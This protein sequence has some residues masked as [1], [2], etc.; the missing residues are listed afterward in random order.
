MISNK[1]Y[2]P[3]RKFLPFFRILLSLAA[4]WIGTL[5][6]Y[7]IY[8]ARN[9]SLVEGPYPPH[10]GS[11]FQIIIL[12]FLGIGLVCASIKP[13]WGLYALV[14]FIPLFGNHPSGPYLFLLDILLL[15]IIAN[16]IIRLLKEKDLR[17][18]R[19]HLD[20]PIIL[21]LLISLVSAIPY[22]I[23]LYQNTFQWSDIFQFFR[24]VA[25]V[26][27]H[28]PLYTMQ[29]ILNLL[30][31]VLLYL[32]AI[33]NLD[34]LKQINWLIFWLLV[35]FILTNLYGLLDYLEI[36]SLPLE[37]SE[38]TF[39]RSRNYFRYG[40]SHCV[41]ATFWNPRWYAEYLILV[42]PFLFAL[43]SIQKGYRKWLLLLTA[44]L[45]TIN[46]VLSYARGGWV[47][48]PVVIVC[49]LLLFI[50]TSQTPSKRKKP[51]RKIWWSLG[52]IT[53]ALAL[54]LVLLRPLLV[55]L[56]IVERFSSISQGDVRLHLGKVALVIFTEHPLMGAGLGSYAWN[57]LEHI[58]PSHPAYHQDHGTAHNNHLQILA[59]R[60]ILG[61]LIFGWLLY[62]A[63]KIGIRT[64]Q[65]GDRRVRSLAGASLGFLV[66]FVVYSFV[67]DLFYIHALELMFWLN[68]SLISLAA[69]LGNIEIPQRKLLPKLRM[70]ILFLFLSLAAIKIVEG[71]KTDFG[72]WYHGETWNN[73]F[74]FRWSK[75]TAS[76]E[77][78]VKGTTIF[79]P[80]LSSH[81]DIRSKPV[82]VQIYLDHHLLGETILQDNNWRLL[83][84]PVPDTKKE[85]VVLTF[86]VDRVWNP[87]VAGIS[88]DARDIGIAVGEISWK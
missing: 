19:T 48:Y 27:E 14:F 39:E 82:K 36:I 78:E 47:S 44:I 11:T 20:L 85:K 61:L 84:Y 5:F 51:R 6:F 25:N 52:T 76:L 60:G 66:G 24:A 63:F 40:P 29:C 35:S 15:L 46:L 21:F 83:N 81:P 77:Q 58:P 53:L 70:I 45:V 16:W 59:E 87:L 13:V 38:Y 31:G 72:G 43:I 79:I 18:Y 17:F 7:L 88:P 68:L 49:M 33:N 41:H 57:Y 4:V 42:S 1:Y 9:I 3:S 65:G 62:L 80:I 8:H 34:N 73:Q 26:N 22:I 50:L 28:Y 74:K 2:S 32:F 75:K 71:V 86:K 30:F 54:S 55:E 64:M 56:K 69:R 37:W 10:W 67:Q 23:Y 12:T